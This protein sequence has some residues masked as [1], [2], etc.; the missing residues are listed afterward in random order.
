MLRLITAMSL[1]FASFVAQAEET[2]STTT[3]TTNVSDVVNKDEKKEDID[4]EITN[5]RMRATLGAKS[6]FSFKSSLGYNGGSLEKPFDKIRPNYRASANAEAL[7]SISGS[8]GVNYRMTKRDNLSLGVGLV[9]SNPFHGDLTRDKFEDPRKAQNGKTKNRLDVSNPSLSWSRGYKA[10]GI[11]MISSAGYSHYTTED[12]TELYNAT[13][14]FSL[15]QTVLADLGTSNL[16][17]GVSLSV[18]AT[19]YNGKM[20]DIYYQIGYQ[21]DAYGFGAFPFA[22]Y[23]FTDKL[24]FRTVFGYFQYVHYMKDNY[25]DEK[26]VRLTP[27][28]SVGI[29][30]SVTRDIYLYPNIQ[31]V[32]EDA[33]PERTNV[34]L[35]TNIN[36]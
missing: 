11:Q 33:R 17:A 23:T 24:S 36:L 31:F 9:M 3:S 30:I 13:G 15:G 27:Y 5:A 35:S 22:E 20:E 18:D 10:F 8:V 2:Q 32:P 34:A 14:N 25:N 4:Q 1:V 26:T 29:G 12:A 28:Q 7:T 19:A 16:S 6:A 21:Q